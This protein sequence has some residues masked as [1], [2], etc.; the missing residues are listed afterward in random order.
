MSP[1]PVFAESET[2][3]LEVGGHAPYRGENPGSGKDVHGELEHT[4]GITDRTELENNQD[5]EPT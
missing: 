3:E 2:R 5:P 1:G 4:P